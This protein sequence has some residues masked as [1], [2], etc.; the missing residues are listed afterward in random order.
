MAES[1]IEGWS[2][3]H[4][5]VRIDGRIYVIPSAQLEDFRNK[6]FEKVKS[7]RVDEIFN[8]ARLT[9]DAAMLEV[10]VIAESDIEPPPR[11]PGGSRKSSTAKVTKQPRRT[12]R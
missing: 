5:F 4:L 3:K 6:R 7:A 8:K 2:D 9:G 1:P 11:R 12:Q 10:V